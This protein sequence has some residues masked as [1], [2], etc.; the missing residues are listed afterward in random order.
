MNNKW[1]LVS[2]SAISILTA[3]STYAWNKPG[4]ATLT[5]AGA[6]YHYDHKRELENSAVPNASLA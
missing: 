3:S 4:A 6:Y 2:M 1:L 5:L